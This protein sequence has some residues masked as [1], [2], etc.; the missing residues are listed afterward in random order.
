MPAA[1]RPK[2]ADKNKFAPWGPACR[3]ASRRP[4]PYTHRTQ[5]IAFCVKP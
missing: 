2:P 4:A 5:L 3:H 1:D